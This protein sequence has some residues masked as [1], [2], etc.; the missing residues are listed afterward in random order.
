MALGKSKN[1]RRADSVETATLRRDFALRFGVA[2]LKVVTAI[3]VCAGLFF[4]AR[5][6]RAWAL[7]APVFALKQVTFTGLSR[8]SE[9]DLLKL[10]GLAPGQNF[11]QL[12]PATLEKT[13]AAHPWVKDVRVSR[14]FPSGVSVQ[15]VE[16]VPAAIISLGELYLLDQQ[17]E[18]FKKLQSED[19]LDL[20]LLT[21]IDR[22]AFVEKA[23]ES[24]SR[25]V[26]ALELAN[27]YTQAG[28]AKGFA[29][30]EVRLGTE[31]VA[32]VTGEGQEVLLGEGDNAKQLES[33]AKVRAEL[34]RR[35]LS[36]EVIHLDNRARPGW[37]TVQVSA[38]RSERTAEPKR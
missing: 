18:P 27:R 3:A 34:S 38:L 4:G 33:L 21:G 19:A 32:L 9:P 22:E 10:S 25:A 31:G 30:S 35:G 28:L 5:Y 7:Q 23:E 26:Q 12:E 8:A 37:V 29:L 17:G 6:G 16:H 1:R 13:M 2:A 11:F 14:H 24:A 36:A 15:V 20:P